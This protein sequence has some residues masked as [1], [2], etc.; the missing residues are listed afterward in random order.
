M[1]F[2]D[3]TTNNQSR[4]LTNSVTFEDNWVYV[5]GVAVTGDWSRPYAFNSLNDFKAAFGYKGPEDSKTFQFVTG[6]LNAGLPVLF[7]R[8]ACYD[9]DTEN[10]TLAVT[11]ATGYAC[12]PTDETSEEY[13]MLEFQEKYG[14]TFGN[15]IHVTIRDTG[16]SVWFD[17]YYNYTLLESKKVITYT[18]DDTTETKAQ[19]IIE[20]LPTITFERIDVL[21]K[22]TDVTKFNL[23][24]N[25]TVYLTG[26]EDF[27]E[28]TENGKTVE[29]EIARSFD[30]ITDKVLYQP[31]FLT[32]GGYTDTIEGIMTE[33]GHPIADKMKEVSQTRQDCRALIDLPSDADKTEQLELAEQLAYQQTSNTQLI[34]SASICAPWCYMQ[35]GNN[36]EWMPPSYVY[37]TVVGNALSSGG[38][39]YTP[40]AGLSTG[41]ITNIIKPQFELGSD[42]LEEWQADGG[43]N[44]NPIM[45]LQSSSYVIA[46]NSTLLRT[47]EGETNAFAESSADL[48]VIEIRRFIYN[49]A[50]EL[51]YQYNST[52][53][54]ETFSLKAAKF[55]ESMISEGSMTDYEIN[56][57]STNSEPRKLKIQLNVYL[58]PT[59]KSIEL[60]L[61]VSYG[62]VEVTTG[63]EE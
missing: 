8:I 44:I 31:K 4:E 37:L 5:P 54:F 23:A 40:K 16:Y 15:S 7:R 1:A 57:I 60:Y 61:N 53:A 14:G 52:S 47:D 25:T 18:S 2:V 32:S 6:L 12:Y 38:K 42:R 63:G 50:S 21:V 35:I 30:F 59:I 41:K 36:Q 19:K 22:Q 48:T 49:L 3:I 34:P 9:Q 24:A 62:S 11:K 29:A 51:Q 13:Q 43:V 58:S 17:V 10:E 55:F 20:T 46:G 28:D 45:R 39:V 56:N 27:K 26:G 33:D